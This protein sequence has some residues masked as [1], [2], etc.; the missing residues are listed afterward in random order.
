MVKSAD[1]QIQKAIEEGAFDNLP[2]KGKPMDLSEN[3][4][5]D[6]EWRLANKMLKDA[7]YSLSWIEDSKDI[8]RDLEAARAALKNAWEWE[9]SSGKRSPKLARSEAEWQHAQQVFREKI[10]RINKRIFDYNLQV[11]S[12]QLQRRKIEIEKELAVITG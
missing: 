9:Q 10:E 2:G 3:P 1:E 4:F 6:P 7:G 8:D 12:I 5:E 11:P